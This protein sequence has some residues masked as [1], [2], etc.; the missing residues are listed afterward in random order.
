MS[1]D[2]LP[3][4]IPGVDPLLG[5]KYSGGEEFYLEFLSDVYKII[6]EKCAQI[7]EFLEADDIH[8]YTTLVHALKTTCRMMGATEIAEGFYALEMHGKSNETDEIKQ[9]TPG[10]LDSFKAL[11]PYLEPYASTESVSD[12]EYDK[13]EVEASL[14]GLKKSISAFDLAGAEEEIK[15]LRRYSYPESSQAQINEL[16]KLVNNLDYDE[17][18]ALIDSITGNL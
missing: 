13:A 12:K 10:V 9:K 8:E 11:K 3:V 1:K 6:D 7:E 5:I 4:N 15:S 14:N 18:L 2:L 17:A 16:E